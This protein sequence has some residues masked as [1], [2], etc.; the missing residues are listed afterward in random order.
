[1]QLQGPKCKS[2]RYISKTCVQKIGSYGRDL[3]LI[4]CSEIEG[5]LEVKIATGQEPCTGAGRSL[6]QN[7]TDFISKQGK[8]NASCSKPSGERDPAKGKDKV[9]D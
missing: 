5:F 7:H 2:W 4:F 9:R 1:M 8:I 6:G 3:E